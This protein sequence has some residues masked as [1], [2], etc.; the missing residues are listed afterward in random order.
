MKFDVA[1]GNPP[2]QENRG[3]GK[4][5]P[6]Y[7]CFY[8]LAE[9]IANKYILI[10]P[11]R[12][13]FGT[14]AT[15]SDWNN[16]MLNDEHLKV[17]YFNQ[18]SSEVFQNTDITGGV[19]VVY[20]DSSKT[21]GAIETFTTF[22]ELNTILKKVESLSSDNIGKILYGVT[23]YTFSPK[24]YEEYPE[25]RSRVGKGSGNQLISRIFDAAPEL[26]LDDKQN[27][28]QIQI[29]GR[30]DNNRIYKWISPD[31]LQLPENLNSY[32]VFIPA[33][34]GS[35]AIG[36]VKST[37][38]IG[39]PLIGEPL[40]GHTATF[41]SIGNFR[42]EFEASALLK[43]LKSKLARTMLGIKKNTQHNKT[44][45]V[46]SKVPLQDFT[47][48]SDIDWSKPIPEIDQQL[49]AKYSLDQSEIDFIES[50]VKPMD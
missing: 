5:L 34:N 6:I 25:I 4:D 21:Y 44:K 33:A 11:A 18:K 23:S 42:T 16:K 2:Y 28:D 1:V 8:E 32:K 38:L 15:N 20:R 7:P 40:T 24:T 30:Q 17:V 48:D 27:N 14:G 31:Y 10:S 45:D 37:A 36:E 41:I 46:W 39:S 12:F 22:D 13:L 3:G 19:A 47:S 35:G 9:K 50:K 29:Y 26:F 43:Y 49:Y